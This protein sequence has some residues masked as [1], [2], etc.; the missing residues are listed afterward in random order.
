MKGIVFTE[1]LEMVEDAYSADLV[2][3]IID[4]ADLESG[5][6]YT[7]VAVYPHQEMVALV[8][9]LCR[10]TGLSVPDALKSFGH[11]LFG[12]FYVLYPQFFQDPGDAFAFLSGIEDVIH[13]EVLKLYP[14]AELPRFHIER[15]DA[16]QLIIRY[17]SVRHLEDLAEGLIR[18]CAEHFGESI[19]LERQTLGEGDAR[20][21]LF[22][23]TRT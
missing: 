20:Q 7:A 21:E 15:H 5:G 9:A 14:D 16:S 2:D 12:R 23:L 13:A 10:R 18:G 6:V 1:F 8:G 17:E 22:L 11:Y 19:T 4:D 3:D